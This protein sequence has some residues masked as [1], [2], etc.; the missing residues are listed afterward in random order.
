MIRRTITATILAGALA[1]LVGGATPAH[2]V[3]AE[4]IAKASTPADHQALAA[5]YA[6]EAADAR[7]QAAKHRKMA[8]T[9]TSGVSNP[10]VSSSTKGSMKLHCERLAH[11]FDAVAQEADALAAMHRELAAKKK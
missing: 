2:A 1:A 4:E 9:Y 8:E 10:K 11:D 3:S 5:Q 7:A 6:K